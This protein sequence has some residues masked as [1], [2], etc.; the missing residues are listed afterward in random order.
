VVP[1]VI[2]GHRQDP[3]YGILMIK[4]VFHVLAMLKIRYMGIQR[5]FMRGVQ[6]ALLLAMVVVNQ[7][8]VLHQCAMNILA[9]RGGY[10]AG[11]LLVIGVQ[12]PLVVLVVQIQV[13]QL[14]II[15]LDQLVI[16]TVQ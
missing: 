6:T 5:V 3:M 12:V 10:R 9:P 8:A 13:N 2:G 4:S 7:P 16:I 14:L 11:A 1:A 15:H